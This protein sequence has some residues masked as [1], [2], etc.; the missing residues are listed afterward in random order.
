MMTNLLYVGIGGFLGAVSRYGISRLVNNLF[1]LSF[2]PWGT[3]IVNGAGAF[4][5]AY[6]MSASAQKINLPPHV[7]LFL[8]T[9]FLGAFTTFSTFTYEALSLYQQSVLR[10]LLYGLVMLVTGFMLTIAGYL[11]GRS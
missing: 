11:L 8:G 5:L 4:L 9:G 10:G 6:I 1:S 3:I 7:L 2:L